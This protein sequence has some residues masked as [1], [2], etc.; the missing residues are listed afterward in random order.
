MG[1]CERCGRHGLFLKISSMG[2]CPECQKLYVEEIRKEREREKA[3][4]K[5]AAEINRRKSELINQQIQNNVPNA[6]RQNNAPKLSFIEKEHLLLK[7]LSISDM[8]QFPMLPFHMNGPIRKVFHGHGLAYIDLD[9]INKAEAVGHLEEI[10]RM[11]AT[12]PQLP[13][14]L[15]SNLRIPISSL[16]YEPLGY[17]TEYTRLLCHPYA[18]PRNIP[19]GKSIDDVKRIAQLPISLYFSTDQYPE[20]ENN[21]THGK[22]FYGQDGLLACGDV[23]FWRENIGYF[24]EFAT[25]GRTFIIKRIKTTKQLDA[26]NLPAT[27]YE[28]SAV[29]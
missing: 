8:R 25:V 19:A 12:G 17:T 22:L 18:V 13:G 9:P 16:I 26:K 11:I 5:R 20:S 3:V 15:P 6:G 21:T 14:L 28:F 1:K 27:I 2:Y 10:N 7:S 24:Y 29:R 4:E 23:C